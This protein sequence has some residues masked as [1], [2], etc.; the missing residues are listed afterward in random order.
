MPTPRLEDFERR[1]EDSF[2]GWKTLIRLWKRTI[3]AWK[4]LIRLWK[5]MIHARSLT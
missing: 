1:V 5:R 3:Q 2:Q 4:S